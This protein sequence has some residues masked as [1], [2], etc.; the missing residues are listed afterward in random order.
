MF[1][2][3]GSKRPLGERMEQR[4][5]KT[6]NVAATKSTFKKMVGVNLENELGL[7]CPPGN[8]WVEKKLIV[9][10]KYVV[11]LCRTKR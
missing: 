6:F 8:D 7:M 5:K 4:S 9:A 11:N 10:C 1:L 3:N 2:R